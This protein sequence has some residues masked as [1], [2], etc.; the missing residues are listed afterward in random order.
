[1]HPEPSLLALPWRAEHN[2]AGLS[3]RPGSPRAA[4]SVL[5]ESS[6]TYCLFTPHHVPRL[7]S[8]WT[9]RWRALWGPTQPWDASHLHLLCSASFS[10]PAGQTPTAPSHLHTC[11]RQ[12]GPLRQLLA[13]VDVRVVGPL[14]GLL[15]LLQLLSRERGP[16]A[17]LLAFQREVGF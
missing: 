5:S 13:G 14:E 8:P 16:T 15:Q 11:L 2:P 7:H 1:M 9:T 17:A 12:L 6:S 4:H 3:A 10:M